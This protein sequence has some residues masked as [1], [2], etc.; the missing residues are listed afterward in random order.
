M[1][2]LGISIAHD[3]G[4]CLYEDGKVVSF[5]K[6]ER[7]SRIKRDRLPMLALNEILNTDIGQIDV[8][9]FCPVVSNETFA[10]NS[11]TRILEKRGQDLSK[12]EFVNLEHEHHLQHASLAFYNSGY[13]DANVIVVDRNGSDWFDGAR[14]S[15]TIFKASYFHGFDAI[16]KNFWLYQNYAQG[17]LNQWSNESG[18]EVDAQ[19][20][21]GI[22]KVYESATTLIGENILENG[23]TMGLSAYGDKDKIF[24]NFFVE[25]TNVPNDFYLS[26]IDDSSGNYQSVYRGYEDMIGGFSKDNYQD[27]AD[28]SWQVQKQTQEALRFL[29]EKSLNSNPTKNV[30]IT[31]GYGLNVVAN[32]YLLKM[33][34]DLNFYFEPMADDSGNSI[35]GAMLVYRQKTGDT[36]INPLKNL[37]F[38]GK[39]HDLSGISGDDCSVSEVVELILDNKYVAVF[40]ELAES[41]P[42]SLGNRSILFNAMNPNAKRLV[43]LIKKREW[44][45]PFAL[46]VLE[47]DAPNYFDMQGLK[48]SKFMTVSFD[49]KEETKSLFPGVVHVDGSCR[50]QTVSEEDG[51]LFQILL[52]IKKLSGHGV[53][54][55]T[56]FNL[57]GQ[58]LVDSL[59]DALQVLDNSKL[60]AVF[61]PEVS[62][63]VKGSNF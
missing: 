12:I 62:K 46:S 35:G 24:P 56:S 50:I 7:I 6:E 49:A 17:R 42:R 21:F 9:V 5:F 28:L 60:S 45:R 40:N 11:A 36:F 37:F 54:L 32:Q 31:G 22:V 15:E 23:K 44:Y 4:V 38:H 14:E 57:A 27:Y 61:F 29:V 48:S 3:A 10:I 16:Y 8:V 25:G 63:I 41:G 13:K 30:V 55:N 53:V 52:Q 39:S 58:P 34:P 1:K 33:F 2:I 43:N 26:H 51:V 47:S 20:L 59:E 19:S 18:V